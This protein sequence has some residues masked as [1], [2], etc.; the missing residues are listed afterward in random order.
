[1]FLKEFSVRRYGPLP[2]SGRIEL[3]PF[4]LFF[5]PNEEGKT[6]TID[7][8][9][10]MMFPAREH[11]NFAG[12]KRVAESPEGYLVLGEGQP[13]GDGGQS[14]KGSLE[15][16]SREPGEIKLPGAGALSDYFKVNAVEFRNIFLIRDSDLSITGEEN[17]YRSVTGRLTGMR[18]DEIVRIKA[19]LHELGRITPGGDF[20]NTAPGKLKD[21]LLQARELLKRSE[22]LIL[23]LDEEQFSRFEEKLARLGEQKR[24]SNGLLNRYRAAYRRERYEKGRDALDKLREARAELAGLVPFSGRDYEAWQRSQSNQEL[25]NRDRVRLEDELKEKKNLVREASET[26]GKKEEEFRVVE[27]LVRLADERI[28]PHLTRYDQRAAAG[29]KDAALIEHPFFR[30]GVLLTAPVL[31]LSLAGSII[32]PQWWLLFLFA[33]TLAF[34]LTYGV[35]QF[36]GARNKSLLAEIEARI[37][38]EAEKLGLPAGSLQ[39]VRTAAGCLK[40]DRE[41]AFN[42]LQEAET[43]AQWL[44]RELERLKVGLEEKQNHIA[45][46]QEVISKIRSNA[47]VESLK[48]YVTRLNRKLDLENEVGKQDSILES[49]FGSSGS[50]LSDQD[51]LEFFKE[52]IENLRPYAGAEKDLHYEQSRVDNLEQEI[53]NLD[54]EIAGLEEALARRSDELRMFEKELNGLFQGEPGGYLPCQTIMDLE[55]AGRSIKQWLAARENKRE[56]ALIALEIFNR[57]AAEEEQ[58]VTA[59]FGASKPVSAFF[60]KITSGRYRE[61]YFDR[62]SSMIKAVSSDGTILEAGRLSGGAYDQL[63]FSIRLALGQEL[64]EGEKGFFILDDPFIKADAGR[65]K[66]MLHIL[67]GISA[68]GWQILYFSAKSEIKEA[69]QDKIDRGRVRMHMI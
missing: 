1:M 20:Q 63:Y 33:A 46:E 40:R 14:G 24:E 55:T 62:N 51:R 11:K 60:N 17:F 41:L 39:A 36:R 28:E 31:I 66:T 58:K 42:S 59:L 13:A 10:K 32:R 45:R 30:K 47:A 7:A 6:L 9:L 4:N 50:R 69:L 3:G 29:K 22:A 68:E 48:Q 2:D 27:Q 37:C 25:F 57:I 19:N 67:A 52:Q 5:A 18:S 49:H 53:E 16:P 64:L 23:E 43:E 12:I 26:L 15:G 8:L 38:S 44:Q 56:Q 54:K 34:I 65:L 35:L 21:R 61:V